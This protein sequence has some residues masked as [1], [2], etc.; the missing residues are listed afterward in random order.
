ML[1]KTADLGDEGTPNLGC[2][3][4]KL[5]LA[6]QNSAAAA[7]FTAAG[8]SE[9]HLSSHYHL[10]DALYETAAAVGLGP[11]LRSWRR[12]EESGHFFC[13]GQVLG[14]LT[15]CRPRRRWRSWG[16]H[17]PNTM[18]RRRTRCCATSGCTVYSVYCRAGWWNVI[19]SW[20]YLQRYLMMEKTD[21]TA[22]VPQ[23]QSSKVVPAPPGFANWNQGKKMMLSGRLI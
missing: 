21:T 22:R 17:S 2:C 10:R 18:N 5:P 16:L 13:R 11:D 15:L 1:K 3:F 6:I 23:P 7:N 12:C 8:W 9:E 4:E 19:E 20:I 14:R